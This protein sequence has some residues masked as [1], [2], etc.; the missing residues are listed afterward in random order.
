MKKILFIALAAATV[1]ACN[2]GDRDVIST[3]AVVEIT[4]TTRGEVANA[5]NTSTTKIE[6]PAAEEFEVT[7][8]GNGE[9]LHWNTLAD[10]NAAVAKGLTFV[11]DITYTVI[12][13]HGKK[14]AEG[15]NKPYFEGSNTVKTNGYG[16]NSSVNVECVLANSII[17]IETTNNFNGYF[18]K[19]K[20]IIN[21]VEWNPESEEFLF[22]NSGEVTIICEAVRQA[23]MAA[24]T[25]TTMT[26]RVALKPTTRH[27]VKFDLSSAGNAYIDVTFDNEIVKQ[28]PIDTELNENA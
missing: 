9:S 4:T 1:V 22:M 12:L 5:D 3:E 18:P 24:G 20:F 14:G 16:L 27:T 23:D 10:Y 2:R 13:S 11:S 8:N 25:V 15:Y 28:E 21:D 19:S 26:T 6:V 17:S 7:I